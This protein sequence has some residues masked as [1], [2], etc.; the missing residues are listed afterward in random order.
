MPGLLST[1]GRRR[2][3][4]TRRRAKQ[5]VRPREVLLC[6]YPIR[7]RHRGD[8]STAFV[9]KTQTWSV[10]P[11]ALD[12]VFSSYFTDETLFPSGTIAFDCPLIMPNIAHEWQAGAPMYI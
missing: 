10:L 6:V 11:L 8:A 3:R 5:E 2:Y 7:R 1:G 12:R 4:P 9:L